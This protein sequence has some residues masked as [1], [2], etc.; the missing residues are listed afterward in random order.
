MSKQRKTVTFLALVLGII[1]GTA[2]T[3]AWMYIRQECQVQAENIYG[4]VE[5]QLSASHIVWEEY[6]SFRKVACQIDGTFQV[7]LPVDGKL[8]VVGLKDESMLR[9]QK[10]EQKKDYDLVTYQIEQGEILSSNLVKMY[11]SEIERA[12]QGYV[13]EAVSDENAY[14]L[15]Y[16]LPMSE[17]FSTW[18]SQEA[19]QYGKNYTPY[20]GGFTL[21][22]TYVDRE[23]FTPLQVAESIEL[24]HQ[25]GGILDC[26]LHNNGTEDWTYIADLPVLEIWYNGVWLELNDGIDSTALAAS[27]AAGESKEIAILEENLK[28]YPDC[29][30]G[31]YRLVIYGQNEC[32]VSD[33]F[34]IQ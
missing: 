28:N 34:I 5:N 16:I 11:G 8:V 15:G 33:V 31:L 3:Y 17:T 19:A 23:V 2:G 21:S 4:I 18:T 12:T 20:L 6:P 22:S 7:Q 9:E 13:L 25:E 27:C 1:I 32:A 24:S 30:P 14:A 29:I 10:R 26:I